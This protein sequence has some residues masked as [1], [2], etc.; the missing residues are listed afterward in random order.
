MQYHLS[1]DR[2]VKRAKRELRLS[3]VTTKAGGDFTLR[4]QPLPR[5]L[6]S[7]GTLIANYLIAGRHLTEFSI[8]PRS[9]FSQ[10]SRAHVKIRLTIGAN[11][12]S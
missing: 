7:G 2:P 5:F 10:L 11:A 6:F 9:D 4:P 1:N 3:H 8:E 12:S